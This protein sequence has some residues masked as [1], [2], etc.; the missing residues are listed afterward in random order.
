MKSKTILIYLI[1]HFS[2]FAC[3]GQ[4]K[5]VYYFD[6]NL[7]I[8][9]KSKS[10]STGMGIM[11]NNL[12]KLEVLNN[13]T[14][15]PVLIAFFTD[16][17]LGIMQG[18]SQSFFK[19]GLKESEGNYESNIE[20]G[21]WI[22][23][24]STGRIIDSTIYEKGKKISETA[25]GYHKNGIMDS[26]VHINFTSDTY[27]RKYYDDSARLW[28]EV[29]FIGQKGFIKDYDK[30]NLTSSDSVFSRLEIEAEPSGG[31]KAWT[32]YILSRLQNNADEIIKSGEYGTCIV[33]FIVGKDGKIR[34]AEAT[35]MKGTA[36]AELAVTIIKNG[37]K[38][39]PA[40]QYGRAV[41]AYR[42]EPITI[43]Q[44]Q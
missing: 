20:N 6:D 4:T 13:L 41:N 35:T 9:H 39:H 43:N 23:W 18:L 34:K 14:K 22:K 12:L 3:F 2:T 44:R 42:L 17:S 19:N 30:G 31:Q 15:Q 24:D 33:K 1:I 5:Y 11:E 8:T 38:W 25:L 29:N 16:S 26:L 40:L 36:L 27:E 21:L 32:Q 28:S 10:V 7:N 37:P